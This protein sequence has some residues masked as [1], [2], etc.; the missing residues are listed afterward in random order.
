MV[1]PGNTECWDYS[2]LWM[3]KTFRSQD[4]LASAQ[5]FLVF[6]V[7]KKMCFKTFVFGWSAMNVDCMMQ[8]KLQTGIYN[9]H[10]RRRNVPCH[11]L[12]GV[13]CLSLCWK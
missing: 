13:F 10:T 7:Q 6:Q 2:S 4:V 9:P 12:C 8:C 3:Y 5:M 11:I 1:E